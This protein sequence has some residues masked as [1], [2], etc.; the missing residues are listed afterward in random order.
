VAIVETH[1]F[2]DLRNRR[3][4]QFDARSRWPPLSGGALDLGASG[5][6]VGKSGF[7]A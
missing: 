7:H 3:I 1:A 5:F 6:E 2:V 4:D